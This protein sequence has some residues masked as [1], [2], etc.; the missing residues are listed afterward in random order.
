V[1]IGYGAWSTGNITDQMIQTYLEHHQEGPN[2][3]ENF[4]FNEH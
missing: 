3:D 2:K 4:I 1:G